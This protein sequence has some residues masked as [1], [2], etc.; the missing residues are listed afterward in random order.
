MN[1]LLLRAAVL[2]VVLLL[3]TV[4]G[5]GLRRRAGRARE[6]ADGELLTVADLAGPTGSPGSAGSLGSPGSTG[7]LGER[8]T[9]VQFSSPACTPCRAVHRVLDAVVAADS[10]LVHVDIDATQRLDLAR[11]LSI[12]RTPTVLLLDPD[13]RVIRRISGVLTAEQARAAVPEPI[14]SR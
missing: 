9:F 6:V 4:A 13:G 14:R 7:S 8:G 3:A 5:V 2:L 1:G 11:R 12:M 10:S